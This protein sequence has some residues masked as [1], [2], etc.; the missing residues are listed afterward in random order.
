MPARV[1]ERRQ[2]VRIQQRVDM[3]TSIE[4]LLECFDV[5]VFGGPARVNG[6]AGGRERVRS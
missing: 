3:C 1:V 6:D 5:A 4:Q 2:V